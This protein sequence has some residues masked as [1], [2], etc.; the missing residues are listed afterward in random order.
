MTQPTASGRLQAELF[1]RLA[2]PLTG[3]AL[4]DCLTDLVF[5][6]KNSRY[7]YVVVNQTLVE[8]CGLA[9]K[10]QLIGHRADEV[11]PGAMGGSYRN[12][13]E[14]VMRSGQSIK[15]Q[16]ELHFYPSGRR[17]WCLTNKV[18]LLDQAGKAIGLMGISKDLHP[19]NKQS[20]DYGK[21]AGVIARIQKQYSEPLRVTELA[22][23]AGLSQYQLEERVRGIFQITAGQLIQQTRMEAA[24]RLL[25]ETD[26]PAGQI[27]VDCGYSDQSAFSRQFRQTVGL[28]PLEYRRSTEKENR[29]SAAKEPKERREETT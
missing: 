22:A 27:A 7:E 18:P 23:E 1:P 11:F 26:A 9:R 15:N 21:I 29:S 24:V 3:E 5:F 8:R 28:S 2:E 10:D 6:I 14:Q 12:Q 13:D 16:L 19:G 17:G 4:F 25:R 20:R